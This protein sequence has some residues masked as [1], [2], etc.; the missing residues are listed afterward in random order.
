MDRGS[1][2]GGVRRSSRRSSD[3]GV[4]RSKTYL[5]KPGTDPDRDE[6]VYGHGVTGVELRPTGFPVAADRICDRRLLAG[7]GSVSRPRGASPI[8]TSLEPTP[9]WRPAKRWC[10]IW[11]QRRTRCT[12]ASWMALPDASFESAWGLR[13]RWRKWHA[14][15]ARRG[16]EIDAIRAIT[17]IVKNPIESIARTNEGTRDRTGVDLNGRHLVVSV[18]APLTPNGLEP[19]ALTPRRTR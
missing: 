18:D 12:C 3:T 4:Q 5:H 15:A 7:K 16:A 6:A 1:C 19:R 14:S 10:E 13:R 9:S 2:T 11:L 17:G 8:R